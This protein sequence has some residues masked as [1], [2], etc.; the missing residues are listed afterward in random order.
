MEF[1]DLGSLDGIYKRFGA[2]PESIVAKI[3]VHALRGLQ[4]L[5]EKNI[6][7]RGEH[8]QCIGAI[9]LL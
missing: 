4:Y 9:I 1:M 8:V 3:A 5:T 7:H 2:V 6:V